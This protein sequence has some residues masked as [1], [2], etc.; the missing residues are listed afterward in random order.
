M[1]LKS[2]WIFR[3][4]IYTGA[5]HYRVARKILPKSKEPFMDMFHKGAI[6]VVDTGNTNV[7]AFE[8]M[9]YDDSTYYKIRDF[10]DDFRFN[11]IM[12]VELY[13]PYKSEATYNQAPIKSAEISAEDFRAL[14]Y[15]NHVWRFKQL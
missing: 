11:G 10:I 9:Y 15:P 4:K 12:L 1:P 7:L 8:T 5:H 14:E 13:S 2:Y 3:N 6:R